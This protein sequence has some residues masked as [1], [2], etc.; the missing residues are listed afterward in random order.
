MKFIPSLFGWGIYHFECVSFQRELVC[1][2]LSVTW[3]TFVAEPVNSPCNFKSAWNVQ[4]HHVTYLFSRFTVF[5]PLPNLILR[6]S[7]LLQILALKYIGSCVELLLKATI[8]AVKTGVSN[9]CLIVQHVAV[10]KRKCM[11][12]KPL[13]FKC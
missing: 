11:T 7:N 12:S 8:L 3:N 1:F 9:V 10:F 2:L 13:H 5:I 4:C 6:N